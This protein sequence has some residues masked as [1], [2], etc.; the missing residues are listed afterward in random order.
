MDSV[1]VDRSVTYRGAMVLRKASW[2]MLAGAAGWLLAAGLASRAEVE[3]N[4]YR[5]ISERNAFGI[6]PPPPPPEPQKPPEVPKPPPNV[7]LTGFSDFGEGKTAYFIVNSTT[8]KPAEYLALGEGQE[9]NDIAV[10]QIDIEAETVRVRVN[11]AETTLNYRDHGNKAGA[12]AVPGAAPGGAPAQR[13]ATPFTPP[14]PAG[15]TPS[16]T[17]GGG[18]VIIRRG[19]AA[20]VQQA[21]AV[22]AVSATPMTGA[23]APVRYTAP[24]SGSGVYIPPNSPV[25]P[26]PGTPQ[27]PGDANEPTPSGPT[28]I[29]PK[30]G[31]PSPLPPPLPGFDTPR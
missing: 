1:G 13:G 19:G 30:T 26:A 16:A 8:G 4:P 11:G 3:N 23:A 14:A 27:S 2:K 12:P 22:T 21:P 9:Q 10:L 15:G 7:A 18:P 25:I 17:T 5:V 31:R 29:N 24:S 6:R 20:E 28:V